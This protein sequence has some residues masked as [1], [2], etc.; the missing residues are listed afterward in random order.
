MLLRELTQSPLDEKQIWART[1]N[2]VV[3][4]Y[5]CVGGKRHGRIVSKMAQCYAPVN[6]KAR[7]TLKKTKARLGQKIARKSKMTKRRNPASRRVQAMNK[8]ASGGR[9]RARRR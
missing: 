7:I 4:K 2:K 6:L 8:A 9:R 1:G 3:R 5:R